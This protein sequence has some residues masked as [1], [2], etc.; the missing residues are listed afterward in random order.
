MPRAFFRACRSSALPCSLR[1]SPS[2]PVSLR[3]LYASRATPSREGARA[4]TRWRVA[5][6]VF[7]GR[8]A[9]GCKASVDACV[10]DSLNERD[11]VSANVCG[12]PH[13]CPPN[14]GR[15]TLCGGSGGPSPL[16]P[17]SVSPLR[18]A[19]E[20]TTTVGRRPTALRRAAR[21][22]RR[23]DSRRV[24]T[25]TR[26]RFARSALDAACRQA[27]GT[28]RSGIAGTTTP[29]SSSCSTTGLLT[30]RCPST[31]SNSSP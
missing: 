12:A 19:V 4:D 17:E 7:R 3:T 28:E 31:N 30:T 16:P 9:K 22:G 8:D 14:S 23:P 24:A 5:V 20:P 27:A 6:G 1:A 11:E 15:T 21:T 18:A 29:H 10:Y 26:N 13:G 2:R 25:L